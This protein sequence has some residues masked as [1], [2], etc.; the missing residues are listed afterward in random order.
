MQKT[1][2]LTKEQ[3]N[4]RRQWY[5]VDAAG[6][7]LGKLAVKAADLIRGKNKVDFTP[8]QDCGDYLIIINSDQV[9]LT[10]NKKENEFWYHHSQYIGGI[11]KVSGR[12]MLKK[13]SDKLVYNAVKGMLPDN[14]LSRRWI[15]KVHVFKG[16]KH[17]MEA[18]KPT[19]L[20]WS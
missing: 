16:D 17:N 11:K 2:M 18:Q 5:I 7:V 8:N 12:D 20:N 14:R 6:L 9:V 15:T 10:G 13:Q 3:A 19:T 4:K 1:S